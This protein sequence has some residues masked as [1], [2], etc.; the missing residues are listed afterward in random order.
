MEFLPTKRCKRRPNR[1][2]SLVPWRHVRLEIGKRKGQG[3]PWSF[4]LV[5]LPEVYLFS[6]FIYFPANIRH[7]LR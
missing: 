4:I 5:W 1:G 6:S 2:A 7:N 3:L